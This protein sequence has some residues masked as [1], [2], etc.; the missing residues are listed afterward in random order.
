[1]GSQMKATAA[2]APAGLAFDAPHFAVQPERKV[3]L[4]MLNNDYS[5]TDLL[6]WLES[7]HKSKFPKTTS[8]VDRLHC[9]NG[10]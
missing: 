8:F 5:E 1:M 7:Q 6:R 10:Q 2:F 4:R 3:N 9:R